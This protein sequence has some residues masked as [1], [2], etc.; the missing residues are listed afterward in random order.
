MVRL[1]NMLTPLSLN[2]HSSPCLSSK[3]LLT[4]PSSTSS[5][6]VIYWIPEETV[7]SLSEILKHPPLFKVTQV[8]P[9]DKGYKFSIC[10]GVLKCCSYC[11]RTLLSLFSRISYK[12]RLWRSYA[13]I[14]KLPSAVFSSRC[15]CW[16]KRESNWKVSKS[17]PSN[18]LTP[19]QVL[20]HIKPLWLWRICAGLLWI[21]PSLTVYWRATQIGCAL[22]K[23]QWRSKNKVHHIYFNFIV[24]L[25]IKLF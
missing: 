25:I 5:I 17:R 15:M 8:I 20:T 9:L 19:F 22:T 1:P 16:F 23:P 2:T 4:F 13:I 12:Y 18:R 6:A 11:F 7:H 10:N 24:F 21:N 3:T 14:H